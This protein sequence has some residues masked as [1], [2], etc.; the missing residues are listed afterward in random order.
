MTIVRFGTLADDQDVETER[1]LNELQEQA[2][3]NL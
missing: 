2:R 1:V 3:K